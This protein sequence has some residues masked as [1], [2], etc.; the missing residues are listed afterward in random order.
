MLEYSQKLRNTHRICIAFS[1]PVSIF[2]TSFNV[3]PHTPA[4]SNGT[5]FCAPSHNKSLSL[6]DIKSTDNFG[7]L[8]QPALNIQ[9]SAN[10]PG[11]VF[12]NIQS[13]TAISL[14][15]FINPNSIVLNTQGDQAALRE[16]C[17]MDNFCLGMLNN[18]IESFSLC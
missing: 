9:G 18:I 5:K 1:R 12:H 17:Y 11:P 7:T 16:K 15:G 14:V 4:G 8:F 10:K 2:N 13:H 3:L 6:P